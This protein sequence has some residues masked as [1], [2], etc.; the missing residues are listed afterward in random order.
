MGLIRMETEN[1]SVV[2]KKLN[3]YSNK[4]DNLVKVGSIRFTENDLKSEANFI[5]ALQKENNIS[6]YGVYTLHHNENLF[7]R[8]DVEKKGI[9]LHKWSENTGILMPCWNHFKD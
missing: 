9:N 3:I 5:I 4:F 1:I 2:G 7:A 8:F 6:S